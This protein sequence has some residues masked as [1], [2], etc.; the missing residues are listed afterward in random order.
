MATL[1]P[2]EMERLWWSPFLMW[3]G[4]IKFPMSIFLSLSDH[5]W[6][7]V[8]GRMFTR[9]CTVPKPT[10]YAGPIQFIAVSEPY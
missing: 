5:P 4:S 8:K 9:R 1:T 2:A 7:T 6:A 10:R 3:A